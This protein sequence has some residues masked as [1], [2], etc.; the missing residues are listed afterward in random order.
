MSWASVRAP[1][2]RP[3]AVLIAVV[4]LL[5]LASPPLLHRSVGPLLP[6]PVDNPASLRLLALVLVAGAAAMSLDLMFGYAGQLSFGHGMFF[7]LGAYGAVIMTKSGS[8]GFLSALLLAVLITM[9]VASVVIAVALRTSDIG[10]SM[11]TLAFAQIAAILVERGYL[12]TGGENGVTYPAGSLPPSLVGITNSANVYWIAAALVVVVFCVCRYAVGTSAGHVW[13]AIRENSLRTEVIGYRID[14]YRLA[15][16]VLG[17]TL[18][19]LCGAVYSI[20]LGGADPGLVAL[21]Q[22][23]GLVLMVVLGGRGIL[24]G[25]LLGGVLYTYLNLRL[26]AVANTE[27]IDRLPSVLAVPLSHPQFLLGVVFVGIVLFLPG[28]LASLIERPFRGRADSRPAQAL[29]G[30]TSTVRSADP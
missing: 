18:A 1:R 23:L 20:V 15:V 22:S 14:L 4:A 7:G 5:L 6:G 12:G 16:G 28:G 25:A 17:C 27:G 30:H 8:I 24:W 13:Q 10:F 29:S 26:P 19:G 9:V 2:G 21:S 3:A 11:V